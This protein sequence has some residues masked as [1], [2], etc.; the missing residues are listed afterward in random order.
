MN[1]K[2]LKNIIDKE[3]LEYIYDTTLK[4]KFNPNNCKMD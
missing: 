3:T 4:L 1:E 2:E